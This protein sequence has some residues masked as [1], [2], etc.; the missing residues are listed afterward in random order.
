MPLVYH[1]AGTATC[2]HQGQVMV[3]PS[4]PRVF[5]NGLAVAT[6]LDQF[7][8]VG[9]IFQIPFGVGTK[10]QPCVRVQWTV[11]AARVKA[12]GAPV[13]TQSSV[14]VCLSIEGI[15]QGPPLI[16]AVQPRVQAL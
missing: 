10:P 11:P 16:S 8:I 4:G 1:F 15:L 3:A 7:P 5:E 6:T 12:N 14:G 2:P 13:I 9:C